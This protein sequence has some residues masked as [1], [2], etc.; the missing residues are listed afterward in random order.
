MHSILFWLFAYSPIWII[1]IR[2]WNKPLAPLIAQ[3]VICEVKNPTTYYEK[4]ENAY[5]LAFWT[6]SI[7]YW[8]RKRLYQTG[9]WL[10]KSLTVNFPI[11]YF[12]QMRIWPLNVFTLLVKTMIIM[13]E[14]GRRV[15]AENWNNTVLYHSNA[16]FLH[17]QVC[18]WTLSFLVSKNNLGISFGHISLGEGWKI[19]LATC[20]YLNLKIDIFAVGWESK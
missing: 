19:P 12:C 15:S 14:W 6:L 10:S 20:F 13:I 8:M 5:S 11:K 1:F 17:R 7:A 9:I 16:M 4:K 2:A 18:V 3:C